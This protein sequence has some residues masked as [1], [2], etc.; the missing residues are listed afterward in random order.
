MNVNLVFDAIFKRRYKGGFLFFVALLF[1]LRLLLGQTRH[2]GRAAWLG[3]AWL[4]LAPSIT[5]SHVY[6]RIA[7]SLAF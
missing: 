1:F 2:R 6:W 5:H 7:S 3:L 4:G